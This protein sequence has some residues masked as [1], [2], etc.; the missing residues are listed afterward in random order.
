MSTHKTEYFASEAVRGIHSNSIVKLLTLAIAALVAIA[1]TVS[2]AAAQTLFGSVVGNVTDV[3]GAAIPG[4]TVTVVSAQTNDTRTTET[5]DRGEYTVA[6]MTVGT[7]TITIS[8]PGFQT[9]SQTKVGVT[10]NN[11]SRI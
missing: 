3:S 11:V 6:T 9:Y 8:K 2:P 7:Y 5:N 10:A 4:A 1:V